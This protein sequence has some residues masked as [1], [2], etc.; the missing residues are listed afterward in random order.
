MFIS[1]LQLPLTNF[2]RHHFDDITINVLKSKL[3]H[4][5]DCGLYRF[6]DQ[7][8]KAISVL[9]LSNT[10]QKRTTAAKKDLV[11]L[12]QCVPLIEARHNRFEIASKQSQNN[13]DCIAPTFLFAVH[14]ETRVSARQNLLPSTRPNNDRQSVATHWAV[15]LQWAWACVSPDLRAP[16]LIIR[17]PPDAPMFHVNALV[18]I[19]NPRKY[20]QRSC[21]KLHGKIYA[22]A[23]RPSGPLVCQ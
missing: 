23:V 12:S 10:G 5:C 3:E 4:I 8:L 18:V 21:Q 7:H 11:P 22:W 1:R 20:T 16:V 6:P 19:T 2:F 15:R 14:S 13:S 17:G 9:S